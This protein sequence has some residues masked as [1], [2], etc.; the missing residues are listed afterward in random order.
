M[1]QPVE[2]KSRDVRLRDIPLR[3]PCAPALKKAVEVLKANR[4]KA[5]GATNVTQAALV[6]KKGSPRLM[7]NEICHAMLGREVVPYHLRDSSSGYYGVMKK[8]EEAPYRYLVG[9]SNHEIKREYRK[10]ADLQTPFKGP[11]L[12]DMTM[13]YDWLH[14]HSNWSRFFVGPRDKRFLRDYGY[15]IDLQAPCFVVH[16]VVVA[17]RMPGEY[18][19]MVLKW[20][21]LV[22]KGIEPHLAFA[23]V[24]G[25]Q[26]WDNPNGILQSDQFHRGHKLIGALSIEGIARIVTGTCLITSANYL[27]PARRFYTTSV[28]ACYN[29]M[30]YDA[31]THQYTKDW[32]ETVGHKWRKDKRH[33]IIKKVPP[34]WWDKG[35]KPTYRYD[36]RASLF[37]SPY[38]EGFLAIRYRVD[39]HIRKKG[40]YANAP[41]RP[42]V[43]VDDGEIQQAA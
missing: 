36:L 21:H 7:M 26:G 13:F 34:M 12:R 32:L 43:G 42:D 30:E 4:D 20:A 41:V 5:R 9:W 39:G 10:P 23:L 40:W 8:G 37:Q 1:T 25:I 3:P 19:E 33:A 38:D 35:A 16:F 11:M 22:R 24:Q 27:L 17:W 18:H 14:N 2:F 29:P 28:N 6:G 15:V 31:I